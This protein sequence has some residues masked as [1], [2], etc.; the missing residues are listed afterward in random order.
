M[1]LNTTKINHRKLA[2]YLYYLWKKIKKNSY[3][4]STYI[5]TTQELKWRKETKSND[6]FVAYY[7]ILANFLS[8]Q[9]EN[10]LLCIFLYGNVK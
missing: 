3:F 5:L 2:L 8:L 1:Y 4:C 9:W 6:F 7:L 10:I